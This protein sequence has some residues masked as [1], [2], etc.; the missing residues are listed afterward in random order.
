MLVYILIYMHTPYKNSL[1]CNFVICFFK[2]LKMHCEHVLKAETNSISCGQRTK[3]PGLTLV[4]VFV[5]V[6]LQRHIKTENQFH[7]VYR[8]L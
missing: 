7:H 3:T 2:P 6:L 4:L 8:D 5:T 1:Y